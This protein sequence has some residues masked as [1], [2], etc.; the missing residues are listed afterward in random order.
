MTTQQSFEIGFVKRA[1][2]HG[3]TEKQAEGWMDMLKGYATQGGDML[4]KLPG[5]V[6]NYYNTHDADWRTIGTTA[7]GA[8]AGGIGGAMS[9]PNKLMGGIGGALAGGALGYGGGQYW[10]HRDN[11]AHLQANRVGGYQQNSQSPMNAAGQGV[12]KWKQLLTPQTDGALKHQPLAL[13]H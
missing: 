1:M 12:D 13:G 11:M 8:L 2:E 10:N 7:A 4:K 5:Q 6:Q 9:S 3:L